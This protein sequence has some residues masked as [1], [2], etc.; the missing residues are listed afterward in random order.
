MAF[1]F[2]AV[3]AALAELTARLDH[4]ISHRAAVRHALPTTERIARLVLRRLK[5]RLP[6]AP[7]AEVT[8]WE[9]PACSATYRP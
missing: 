8:V 1:D 6:G 7:L 9:G 2:V 3:R 5:A 4:A